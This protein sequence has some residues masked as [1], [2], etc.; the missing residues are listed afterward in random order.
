MQRQ[1]R[2]G[3]EVRKAPVASPSPA[4]PAPS[5]AGS[6]A[7]RQV[8]ARLAQ[9]RA[10][11][12]QQLCQIGPLSRA[13]ACSTGGTLGSGK[14]GFQLEGAGQP[15]LPPR[16]LAS[17]LA[18]HS[19]IRRG[20]RAPPAGLASGAASLSWGCGRDPDLQDQAPTTLTCLCWGG[21]C[22]GTYDCHALAGRPRS[23]PPGVRG[24]RPQPGALGAWCTPCGAESGWPSNRWRSPAVPFSSLAQSSSC[25][26]P[27]QC[28]SHRPLS[29]PQGRLGPRSKRQGRSGAEARKAPVASPSLAQPAPSWAGSLAARQVWARLA[30]GRAASRQ[31]LCQIGPLS[32]AGALASWRRTR[33]QPSRA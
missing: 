17:L 14:Q 19:P 30:Q 15:P 10:A 26:S 3:A 18:V 13:G 6:L 12:H 9:G 28:A 33:L 24:C 22:Y 32:R 2:S 21:E 5:W 16:R 25:W 1:G 23:Q 31:Q 4:Q 29:P 20:S 27:W 7:V 8:W 11:S